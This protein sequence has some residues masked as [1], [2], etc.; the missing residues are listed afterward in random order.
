MTDKKLFTEAIA[1]MTELAEKKQRVTV[2]RDESTYPNWAILGFSAPQ[3]SIEGVLYCDDP[4]NPA[5]PETCW[6]VSFGWDNVMPWDG[7]SVTFKTANVVRLDDT[8]ST[9]YVIVS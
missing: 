5:D 4:D 2:E 7:A 8:G 9:L 6:I 3:W 1:K